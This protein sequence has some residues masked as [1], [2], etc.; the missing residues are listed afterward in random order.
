MSKEKKDWEK[1]DFFTY[2]IERPISYLITWPL[3]NT[4][5]S[6]NA[7]SF[8][9]MVV[10]LASLI[11]FEIGNNNIVILLIAWGL[12]FLWS[13]LDCVDGNIAR[14]K[15]TN[16][17]KGELWDAVAGYFAVSCLFFSSSIVAFSEESILLNGLLPNT[18]YYFIGGINILLCLLPRLMMH[19]KISTI[20]DVSVASQFVERK[21][22]SLLKAVVNN[23]V[24]ITG[25]PLFLFLFAIIFHFCNIFTLF[26]FCINLFICCY[27]LFVILCR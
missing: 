10:T 12:L 4:G 9:S 22:F 7:V 14:F 19:K 17:A 25:F 23:I 11:M 8:F 20:G 13:I 2:Y 15:K 26:Y 1:V 16:S 24:S 18:F 3:L 6:A 27:S 5:I 21:T